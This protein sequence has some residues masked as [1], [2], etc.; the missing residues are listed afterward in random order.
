MHE[1]I[2]VLQQPEDEVHKVLGIIWGEDDT[3]EIEINSYVKEPG[4]WRA[5]KRCVLKLVAKVYDPVGFV[6]GY[7]IKLKIFFQ[8]LFVACLS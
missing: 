5:T 1:G 6:A 2:E 7:V 8:E 4:S 3:I